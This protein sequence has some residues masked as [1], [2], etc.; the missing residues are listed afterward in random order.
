MVQLQESLV[1]LKFGQTYIPE[2]PNGCK[3]MYFQTG[4]IVARLVTHV[5][6]HMPT[7]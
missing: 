6:E 2:A 3:Y 1:L 4:K 7:L 5:T